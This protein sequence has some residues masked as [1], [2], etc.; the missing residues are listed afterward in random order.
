MSLIRYATRIHFADRAIEDALPEELAARRV[1]A[2]LVV[3]DCDAGEALGRLLECLP[4]G[5]RPRVLDLAGLPAPADRARAVRAAAET[6]AGAAGWDATIGLGGAA[7]LDL[8]RCAVAGSGARPVL[9]VPTLPGCIGLGP[10]GPGHGLQGRAAGGPGRGGPVPDAVFCDPGLMQG[11]APARLAAAGFD[12]LVHCLEALLSS[13]WNPPADGI[14]FDGLR[15]AG[16][17][18]EPLVADPT[19]PQARC[20]M[21][22]AALN[23]ALAAQ[24]GFGAFHALS[25]GLEALLAG[26][27]AATGA[28]GAIVPGALHGALHGALAVPVLAFNAPAVPDRIAAAA[29]ALRLPGPEALAAHLR[30]MAGRLGLPVRLGDLGLTGAGADRVAEAAAE[31]PTNLT[32]PRHATAADYRRMIAAAL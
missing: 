13:A 23:G 4:P 29:E 20:E 19:D 2:P 25:H 10:P 15:R 6:G 31:D 7:A 8:A 24:K 12:A 32:N 11:A 18:L 22:A 21:L 26:P 3:V 30:A 28:P 5:C 27:G 9:M 14:A 17:W 1:A 16:A